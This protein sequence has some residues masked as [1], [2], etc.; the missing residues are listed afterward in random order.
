MAG[1]RKDN[2]RA[3]GRDTTESALIQVATDLFAERGY[4]G[5]SIADLAGSL[6][7][8]T[9]SLYYHVSGKQ[10][11]LL[12]VLE[13]GMAD[14]LS[15]LES[16]SRQDT[17]AQDRLSAAIDNHLDFVLSRPNAVRVFLRERRFLESPYREEYERRVDRYDQLFASIFEACFADNRMSKADL[18]ITR[19]SILGMINWVVEWY[20]EGG[21]ISRAHVKAA[22]TLLILNR[23]LGISAVPAA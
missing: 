10:Q 1:T 21:A 6:G 4:H 3:R 9:A 13:T 7:L 2:R 14:F 11:L 22:M 17:S 16:I 12:R 8:T 15:N 5:T 18:T 20:R 23:L 19:V